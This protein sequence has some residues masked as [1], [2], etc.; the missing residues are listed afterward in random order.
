MKHVVLI[1]KDVLRKSYLPVYGNKIWN[2]P[3]ID[4]LAKK[5]TVFNRHYTAAPSTA[6]A[7][8]SMFT[9]LYPYQTERAT[10]VPIEKPDIQS[11]KTLF[12][13]MHKKGY[14]CHLM[15]SNN[16]I[17][18]AEKF[19]K[20]YGDYTVHHDTLKFNQYIGPHAGKE[21]VIDNDELL[22]K[23][24][25]E[26]M[27]EIDSID[28]S[29]PVFLWIHV[30]HVF[31]GRSC[32][33][34]DIDVFDRFVGDIRERFG[35]YIFITAD[36]GSNDGK[37][38][39]T[40]YGFDLYESSICIPLIAP[41]MANDDYIDYPTSNVD[42]FSIIVDGVI[43]K[44]DF[45]VSDTAYYAQPHRKIAIIKDNYK[46]IYNK[47]NKSFEFYDVI[48]DPNENINLVSKKMY[49]KDRNRYVITK[50]VLYY[51][52]WSTSNE[53]YTEMVEIFKSIWK[54]AGPFIEFKNSIIFSL[55]RFFHNIEGKLR[56]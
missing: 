32:Y 22:E 21:E 19:S 33:G 45:V 7:F 20:C 52:S 1:S 10:Y 38:G 56:K 41:K 15:W 11:E 31:L 47:R 46:L 12:D 40:G 13:A 27:A 6:M 25:K 42:L 24:Y 50:Q 17:T 29:N 44:R 16:Y 8:T 54:K 18:M 48:E 37:G 23:T 35:D 55:K 39:K 51:S 28:R 36:H 9:G 14:S 34:G 43:K 53:R 3:N 5:G 26:I 2:T 30:P 49:D 4:A